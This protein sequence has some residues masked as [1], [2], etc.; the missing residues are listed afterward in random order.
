M[1]GS[2]HFSFGILAGVY[3]TLAGYQ[4]G[5]ATAFV[6]ATALASLVPDIDH[7][8]STISDL[9][10]PIS[11]AYNWFERRIMPNG[12]QH[13]GITHTLILPII[14]LICWQWYQEPL[15]L[16]V[17]VGILSHI[18]LDCLTEQGAPLLWPITK[19]RLSIGL[20]NTGTRG[21][22][23]VH[24]LIWVGMVVLVVQHYGW[25]DDIANAFDQGSELLAEVRRESAK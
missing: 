13:R 7:P 6:M 3:M 24:W 15:L 21:E 18:A 12:M 16:A 8:G 23:A 25:S 4:V 5:D 11:V 22:D 20:A 14:L 2:T 10:K 19:K 9:I 17:S 1:T